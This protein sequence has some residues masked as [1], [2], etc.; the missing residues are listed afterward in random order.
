MS[1]SAQDI[2]RAV[3]LF[4]DLGNIS[5]RRMFG[6]AALYADGQIFAVLRSTGGLYLKAKDA[7]AERL[8]EEGAEPFTMEKDGKI[9]AMGYMSLPD[10]ALDDPALA[11]QWALDALT[12]LET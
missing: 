3:E 4:E 6:G 9:R 1:V 10:A 2:A 11:C 7:F 8:A 12:A 5:T